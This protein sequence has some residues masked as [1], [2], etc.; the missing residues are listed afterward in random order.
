MLKRAV[1]VFAEVG[2]GGGA[3]EVDGPAADVGRAS[4][5]ER[6]PAAVSVI[7]RDLLASC[8]IGFSFL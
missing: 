8:S 4:P 7:Q 3:A 5:I 1:R 6:T 2:D